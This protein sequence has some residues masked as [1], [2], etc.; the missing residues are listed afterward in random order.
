M[1]VLIFGSSLARDLWRFDR[2]RVYTIAGIEVEFIYRFF[3]GKSFEYFLDHP[4]EISNVLSCEPDF[5][6]VILGANSI[7][8]KIEPKPLDHLPFIL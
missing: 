6:L 3:K 5:V 4:Y 1:R 8:T 2:I 7:T